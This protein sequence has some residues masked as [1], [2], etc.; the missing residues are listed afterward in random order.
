MLIIIA[1][2]VIHSMR[3]K[4][5]SEGWMS[6]KVDHEKAFD[7][8]LGDFIEDTLVDARVPSRFIRATML[9]ISSCSMQVLWNGD[10][11]D[12]FLNS[13]GIR[14]GDPLSPYIFVLCMERLS[15]VMM[16]RVAEQRWSSISL[17]RSGPPL[18]HLFFADDLVLFSS[19]S[20]AQAN[21]IKVVL[22]EF[23][24]SS[25]GTRLVTKNPIF[26]FPT[27]SIVHLVIGYVIH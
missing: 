5:G 8:L 6:I 7:R 21:L 16:K 13:R 4:K 22:D 18:S 15:Q 19:T 2:E 1:Q 27:M 24:L 11:T 23:C 3:H 20:M 17:G 14:L 25:L 12:E 10:K 9:C 26:S